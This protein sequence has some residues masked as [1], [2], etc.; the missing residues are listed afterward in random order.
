MQTENFSDIGSSGERKRRITAE[1]MKGGKW[2]QLCKVLTND[3][4]WENENWN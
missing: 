2:K 3:V 4:K 1:K